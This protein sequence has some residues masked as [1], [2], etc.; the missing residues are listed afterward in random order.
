MQ[1]FFTLAYL[2]IGFVQLFAIMDG[3]DYALDIGSVLSAIL[4]F[5][6]TYIP[7][8]G[9]GL[10]IYGAIN[11]WDWSTLQAFALFLW[12]VPVLL[13]FAIFSRS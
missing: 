7:L 6:V 4:A 8:L 1:L 3:I 10:G 11:A 12:Y 5:I 2:F 9:S 13:L